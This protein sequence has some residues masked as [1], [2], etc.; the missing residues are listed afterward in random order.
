MIVHRPSQPK[1]LLA[2]ATGP[3]GETAG[4]TINR[5]LAE[6]IEAARGRSFLSIDC[7]IDAANADRDRI[8][9]TLTA[10]VQP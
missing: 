9:V 10:D 4:A 5:A 8:V 3:V 7:H 2:V 6:L 1:M